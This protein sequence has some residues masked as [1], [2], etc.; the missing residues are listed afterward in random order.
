MSTH[1]TGNREAARVLDTWV[2][3]NR[4]RTSVG[5]VI[6]QAMT[7]HD[8]T[9]S[10]F[11]L[12]EILLHIGPLPLKDIGAKTLLTPSNLVT[13]VDN[14]VREGL[15]ERRPNPEDRR[16]ILVILTPTGH[17]LIQS[18]FDAH[19]VDLMDAFSVLDENEQEQLGQL[20]RKLG[21]AQKDT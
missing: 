21:L 13:V 15:V 5:Q 7:E 3:L 4:A 1:Y 12:M 9:P 18:A 14:L 19:L 16:S 17:D 11:G 20:C 6:K 2:K 10:Q 8:L